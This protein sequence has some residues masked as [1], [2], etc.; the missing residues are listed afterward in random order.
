MSKKCLWNIIIMAL[1]Y[2]KI[3]NYIIIINMYLQD[4]CLL[5]KPYNPSNNI[6]KGYYSVRE[7]F[8]IIFKT[9]YCLF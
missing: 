4:I 2:I 7:Q 9:Y 1:R 3:S 8:K 5:I 6:I